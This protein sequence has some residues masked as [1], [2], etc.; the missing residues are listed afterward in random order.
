MIN[1][2]THF[3]GTWLDADNGLKDKHVPIP[4]NVTRICRAIKSVSSDRVPQVV[5]YQAGVGTTGGP[6][7]RTLGGATGAGLADNVHNAY[8]FRKCV[9]ISQYI[10]SS[11]LIPN[12]VSN[13]YSPGDEIILLGFSRGA[14]TARSVG[15]M[16]A[17][18]GLL[19]KPGLDFLSV[20]FEDYEHRRDKNYDDPYPSVPFPNKPS[21]DDSAYGHELQAV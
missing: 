5:Y 18:V 17:C 15:S 10:L 7:S 19:T 8:S 2:L 3:I 11:S 14:F 1:V 4:S 12:V 6:I 16:I 21:A 9:T 13:N 20:V